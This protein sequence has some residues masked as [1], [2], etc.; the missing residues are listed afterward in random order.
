MNWLS[1]IKKINFVKTTND[2]Y[3][4]QINKICNPPIIIDV[5]TDYQEPG[6]FAHKIWEYFFREV[7][8]WNWKSLDCFLC[9]LKIMQEY[10]EKQENPLFYWSHTKDG[11]TTISLTHQ[12]H[13]N[14][15][16]IDIYDYK[17]HITRL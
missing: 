16:V 11:W 1:K 3:I 2:Q 17:I 9:D 15:Y 13:E 4:K 5:C 12:Y 10:I 7:E 8:A 14:E 6:L